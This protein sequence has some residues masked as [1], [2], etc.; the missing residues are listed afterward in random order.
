MNLLQRL[1]HR[2]G[3]AESNDRVA[4][5]VRRRRASHEVRYTRALGGDRHAGLA[6]HPSDARASVTMVWI[7]LSARALNTASI[8]APGMPKTCVTP[9][10]SSVRTT[11]CES[12]RAKCLESHFR[13]P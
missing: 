6:G 8:F 4:F 10:A 13:D 9:C 12:V 11:D 5:R 3:A 7:L 1:V 2:Y